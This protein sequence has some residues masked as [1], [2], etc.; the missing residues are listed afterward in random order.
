MK[1]EDIEQFLAAM[2][3]ELERMDDDDE[4]FHEEVLRLSVPKGYHILHTVWSHR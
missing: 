2:Q 4:I 3:E 1:A